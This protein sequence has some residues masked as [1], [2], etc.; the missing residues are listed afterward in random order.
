MG[1]R[2]FG[3]MKEHD[4]MYRESAKSVPEICSFFFSVN[5]SC[6]SCTFKVMFVIFLLDTLTK[7]AN[8]YNTKSSFARLN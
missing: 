3:C 6:K 2:R 4:K 7:R 5:E 1:L 8:L